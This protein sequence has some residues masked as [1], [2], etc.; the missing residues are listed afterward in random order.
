MRPFAPL[1]T[2]CLLALAASTA[3][4]L[5]ACGDSG[6]TSDAAALPAV[7]NADAGSGDTASGQSAAADPDV[8]EDEAVLEWAQ[9]MRDNGVDIADPT[10]DADGNV[11]LGAPTGDANP[12]SGEF[13]VASEACGDLLSGTTF[14]GPAGGG[15]IDGLQEGLVAFTT[16]LRDEGLDVGDVDL[17]SGPPVGAA[18]AAPGGDGLSLDLLASVIP[19][20]DPEDPNAQSAVDTCQP[21]LTEAFNA[22]GLGG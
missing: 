11:Q 19:G 22:I 16:C 8:P 6:D 13:Q 14:T 21:A 17:G 20:F 9:C 12:Q 3:L 10:V 5:S 2:R 1:S 7:E 18:G 4:M 15:G